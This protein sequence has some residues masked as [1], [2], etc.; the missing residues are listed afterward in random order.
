VDRGGKEVGEAAPLGEYRNLA[1]SPDGKHLAFDRVANNNTDVWLMDLD[2]RISSRFTLQQSNVPIW[3]PEGSPI[4]FASFRTGV[5]DIYQ[6]P[7]NMGAP[8]EV[9]LK[10]GARP[11]VFPSDW[12][13][14]GRYIAYYRTDPKNQLD[15]WVLPM[16]GDRKQFP[17]VH[18][19]FN[20][21]QGQFSPDGKWMAYVSDESGSPQIYVQS[22][23][24]LTG[25]WQISPNGGGQPRWRPDGKELYYVAPDQKLMAV[26]VRSG[27]TFEAEAPRALF[28]TALPTSPQRQTYAVS[29]DGQR[30][31]LNAPLDVASPMTIVENWTAGLKK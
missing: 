21:S 9:L 5:L 6:R 4:A 14:D 3:S 11:I 22:F 17:Y 23:P 24:G 20:E 25:K 12:S 19:E 31:L 27:A 18:G 10:L 26:M 13:S 15:I 1:L 29:R 30:F 16:F 28:E 7:A 8:D 2:R